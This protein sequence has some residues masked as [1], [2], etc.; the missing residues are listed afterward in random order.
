[1]CIDLCKIQRPPSAAAGNPGAPIEVLIGEVA[2]AAVVALCRALAEFQDG[3]LTPAS[4]TQGGDLIARL[5][6]LQQATLGR[7][8]SP[9]W[10]AG[11]AGPGCVSALAPG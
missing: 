1:L 11:K 8:T 9:P 4:R 5:Y 2:A 6:K 10:C 7:S 3:G